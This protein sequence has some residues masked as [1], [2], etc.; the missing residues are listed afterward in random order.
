MTGAA[1]TRRQALQTI[2]ATS[3]AL[4]GTEAHAAES[5]ALQI[6]SKAVTIRLSSVSASTVRIEVLPEEANGLQPVPADGALVQDQWG[7]PVAHL[8]KQTR[9][10]GVKCGDLSVAVTASPLTIRVQDKSNRTIQE[11]RAEGDSG[12]ISFA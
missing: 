11:L 9:G 6:G 3:T 2:A 10:K 4:F 7:K 1:F 5:T 12:N 8:R